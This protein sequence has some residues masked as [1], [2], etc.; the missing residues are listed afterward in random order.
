MMRA[1]LERQVKA[2]GSVGGRALADDELTAVTALLVRVMPGAAAMS[3]QLMMLVNLWLAGRV[4]RTS[5]RL[6]RPWPMLQ[7][8]ELPVAATG[9]LA[10]ALVV[11]FGAT[12]LPALVA[13]GFAGALLMAHAV[14]GLA[15][16]HWITWGRP[17]RGLVLTAAYTGAVLFAPYGTVPVALLGLFEPLA[18]LRRRVPGPPPPTQPARPPAA[19]PS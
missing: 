19:G 6:T 3:W 8:L 18:R 4:L 11:A 14:L 7:A 15:V 12:G 17:N 1:L 16:L 2:W 13:T 10:V 5:G 9:A